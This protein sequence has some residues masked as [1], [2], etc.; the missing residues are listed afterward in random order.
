M[1]YLYQHLNQYCFTVKMCE[2]VHGIIVSINLHILKIPLHTVKFI[3]YVKVLISH[4]F[5]F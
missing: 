5:C 2:L 4:E 1:Y 3:I